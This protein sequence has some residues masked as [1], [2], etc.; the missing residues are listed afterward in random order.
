MK[1]W[2]KA[3]IIV[4]IVAFAAVARATDWAPVIWANAVDTR[5]EIRAGA[6]VDCLEAY[7]APSY[8]V[9]TDVWGVR[10][11]GL[12]NAVDANM[13]ANLFGSG[14]AL[15][16]GTLY[17]GVFGGWKF[18]G[19]QMEGGYLFGGRVR[20]RENV[21]WTTEYQRTFTDFAEDPD[22]YAVTTGLRIKLK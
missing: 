20:L 1:L 12:Y 9:T 17:V 19:D 4:G 2:E 15:P 7:V 8:N 16:E 3:V 22:R 10:A 14:T 18:E 5:Y 21:D 11:Y 6:E 13:I